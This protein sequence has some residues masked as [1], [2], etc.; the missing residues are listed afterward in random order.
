MQNAALELR[1]ELFDLADRMRRRRV[2][3]PL[4][5]GMTPVEAR[6]VMKLGF[7]E[8]EG[9]TPRPGDVAKIC[10][11]SPSAISQ[12]LKSLEAKGLIVRGR[13]GDDCR[14]V[15]IKLTDAGRAMNE[16]GRRMHDARLDDLIA[17]LGE[18]DARE[19]I[20]IVRRVF[21][22]EE[23][24][25]WRSASDAGAASG[26]GEVSGADATATAQGAEG[27]ERACES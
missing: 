11:L 8:R 21:E 6:T 3:P 5:E 14:A 15:S 17:F 1:R 7:M 26:C 13:D 25:P 23:A 4:P 22:F 19:L 27:E 12:T 20:R 16:A 24:C 9:A 2:A 10:H 18:D